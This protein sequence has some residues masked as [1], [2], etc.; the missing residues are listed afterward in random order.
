MA[1]TST[2]LQLHTML[3]IQVQN[4]RKEGLIDFLRYDTVLVVKTETVKKLIAKKIFT[5]GKPPLQILL[6]T[7]EN[8]QNSARRT[9]VLKA[10]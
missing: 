7:L 10:H 9:I 1:K 3:L 8:K 4:V 6:K 5:K 2:K